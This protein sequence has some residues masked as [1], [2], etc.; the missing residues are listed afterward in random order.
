[1]RLH[2]DF[3]TCSELDLT[4]VG[5]YRYAA[6]R[7][8]RARFLSWAID[9]E[10]PDV[11]FDTEVMPE[12]LKAALGHAEVHAWNAQFERLIFQYCFDHVVIPK[13]TFN[14]WRCT[15][16]QARA[17]ALPGKLAD[18]ARLLQIDTP[19][20]NSSIMKKFADPHFE[21]TEEEW[22]EYI[23]YGLQ[24]V[25]AERNINISL[26]PLSDDELYMYQINE[27]INDAGV[28]IDRQFCNSMLGYLNAAKEDLNR[29]ITEVTEGGITTFNQVARIKNFCGLPEKFKLS[30]DNIEKLRREP[31]RLTTAQDEVLSIRVTGAKASTAKYQSMTDQCSDRDNRL[32]GMFKYAGAGQTGRFSGVG[33]Q[34][35]NLTRQVDDNAEEK[36]EA[37]KMF[38]YSEF[39][40]TYGKNVIEQASRLIR[41]ALMAAPGHTFVIG[42]YSAVE[43]RGVPWLAQEQP[44][45]D[46]WASGADRYIEDAANVFGVPQDEVTDELRQGGKVVRLACGFGG[47]KGA[48]M[49]MSAGYGLDL[50]VGDA[51][52]MA[53][54]WHAANPWV[55]RFAKQLERAAL[56]AMDSP[57][58]VVPAGAHIAYASEYAN[59]K[60][61]LRCR[62]PSGRVISYF[63]AK[64]EESQFGGYQISSIKPRSGVR[65]R[66]WHGLFSENVTQ[67]TCND[68]MRHAMV[69][70]YAAGYRIVAHVHDETVEEVSAASAE[71]HC[72]NIKEIMEKRPDWASDFP[73]VAKVHTSDRYTK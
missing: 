31:G 18:A 34:L 59:G 53:T 45:I 9:D 19:K 21:G 13:P 27:R 41:P 37:V 38:Q 3:E 39:C 49:Q 43:A 12:R 55:E 1:M 64:L 30:P 20:Q 51:D 57:G 25:R 72:V 28:M 33:P 48:L 15:A 68:L 8:T 35:H 62:L 46:A 63:D 24:D 71:E 11:W 26:D 22:A 58:Q 66:L 17:N 14:Q 29:R 40:L 67:A 36:I 73:L 10:E 50:T 23:D 61:W 69:Q 60:Q 56:A 54:A 6:H 44:E 32:R 7:S 5:A 16:A 52:A 70:L 42:D 47:K 2:I 65:E 4:K